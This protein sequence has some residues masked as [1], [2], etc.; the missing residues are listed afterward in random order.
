MLQRHDLL[1]IL[2]AALLWLELPA[3]QAATLPSTGLMG[4][5]K[6]S[7]GKPMEGVAVSARASDKRFTTSVYTDQAGQY[8]F[9][10]LAD[11][12]YRMW[13]QAVGFD[14]A[15]AELTIAPGKKIQQNF[16]LK[17][18]R[19]FSQQLSG[20]E[21]TDSLPADTPAD[22]R[23]SR[24]FYYNCSTC[25]LAGYV[26]AKRFD[27]AGWGI[28]LNNMIEHETSPGSD[29]RWLIQFYKEDLVEYLT[30]IRGPKPYPWK[31]QPHPRPSGEATQIVVTE[32]DLPRGDQP[33][34]LLS[35]NGSDWA[36]GIPAKYAEGGGTH[37]AVVDK[38]GNVWF[39]DDMTPERTIGK[40]DPRTGLTTSYKLADK[41]GLAVSTHGIVADQNGIVW[42]PIGA[43]GIFASFD[44]KTGKFQRFP[45]PSSLSRGA[46]GMI[47]VD[48]KGNLWTPH[49][50]GFFRLNPQTGEVENLEVL[51][52]STRLLRSELFELPVT[53]EFHLVAEG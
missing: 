32:Y 18:L 45:K 36:E 7:E 3:L 8:F 25:H 13:A 24:V 23:M 10:P 46:G 12:R 44:P 27:A 43:E 20:T 15:R 38:D 26:L 17:P 16:T 53:A 49:S 39:T 48:S 42:F 52:F 28:I 47:V 33:D 9:P 40:L 1:R 4:V 5:V 11:G 2:A 31:F 14:T 51:F 30:R 22:R 35:H 41:D 29:S 37:D 19:D 21:W 6:S 50:N 34:F